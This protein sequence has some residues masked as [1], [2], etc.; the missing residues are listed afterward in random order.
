MQSKCVTRLACVGLLCSVGLFIAT[1]ANALTTSYDV[2]AE[3][4]S[5][6][7][8]VTFWDFDNPGNTS[9]GTVTTSLVGTIFGS[10]PVP[11]NSN[12]IW[13]NAFPGLSSVTVDLTNP[14]TYVGF[15]W[16][17][18][19]PT[20]TVQVYDAANNL[21]ATYTADSTS[22][23]IA[24]FHD[25]ANGGAGTGYFNL[26]A[27]PGESI[28]RLVLTADNNDDFEVDNF[29][30]VV[31]SATTPLPAALPLFASGAGLLGFFGWRTK[32]KNTA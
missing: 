5:T 1:N 24:Q 7:N 20:N 2:G 11:S 30:A 16:G 8:S 21:L 31:P 13:G 22:L 3:V 19:D 26:T 12:N 15:T 25:N 18:P 10:N 4:T 6:P 14:A 9:I 17:T 28:G 29:S 23:N 32:R 27:G